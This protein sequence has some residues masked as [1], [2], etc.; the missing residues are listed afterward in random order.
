[1]VWYR[2]SL[3]VSGCRSL[4]QRPRCKID[5]APLC[6][7]LYWHSQT[8][9]GA[10]NNN[11]GSRSSLLDRH[12]TYIIHTTMVISPVC[13]GAHDAPFSGAGRLGVM[14]SAHNCTQRRPSGPARIRTGN[15]S[16]TS[17][18]RNRLRHR[19]ALRL[20]FSQHEKGSTAG[21]KTL[22]RRSLLESEGKNLQYP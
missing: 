11:N 7:P 8:R 20:R 14:Q 2:V 15:L 4:H 22:L 6:Q 18:R 17:R 1:M 16:I 12:Y 5:G 21:A 10:F 9:F 3:P 19:A 13:P